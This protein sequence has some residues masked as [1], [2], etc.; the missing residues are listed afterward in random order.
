MQYFC[1]E[2][3]TDP[4]F[5]LAIETLEEIEEKW[6][7]TLFAMDPHKLIRSLEDLSILTHAQVILHASRARKASSQFL[8]FHR[9]DYPQVDP[10]EWHKFITV[11]R[12]NG[13]VKVG[14]L[15]V[16]YWGN[17]K[18]D[19]EAHNRDYTCASL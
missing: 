14:E 3:K 11:K 13:K 16:D 1:S 5:S 8:N 6:V 19:Y 15:P 9:I 2:Y 12:E 4:L 17:L 18:Q 7:P 10:P